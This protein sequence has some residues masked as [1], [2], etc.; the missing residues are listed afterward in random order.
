MIERQIQSQDAYSDQIPTLVNVS[1]TV[2]F[3]VR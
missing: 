2:K 3:N 1:Y